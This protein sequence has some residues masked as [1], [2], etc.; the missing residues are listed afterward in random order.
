MA[1][2]DIRPATE[3]DF[4]EVYGYPPSRSI[5]GYSG[6]LHGRPVAIAGI[7]YYPDQ[8][9]AF[10]NIRPE[11]Y[12]CRMGLA[13]GVLRVLELIEDKAVPVFAIADPNIPGA[14]DFLMRCGFQYYLKSP[15][16][17]VFIWQKP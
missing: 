7:Y 2:L 8:V 14:E 15:N 4:E 3:K 9:V 1:R 12:E 5:R 17:E 13:R 16:G 6:Y 10:C 11:A